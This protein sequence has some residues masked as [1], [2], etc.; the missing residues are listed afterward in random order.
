[1]KKLTSYLLQGVLLFAPMTVTIY[2]IYLV[3]NSLDAMANDLLKELLGIHIWGL[4][5]LTMLIIM[6]LLGYMCSTF[7]VRS[8]LN[9]LER[10]LLRTPLVNMIYGS[11]KDLFSAFVSDQKKFDQPVLVMINKEIGLQKM[12]FLT[13]KELAS[14][15]LKDKVGVYLPHS[16]NFSGNF[17]IIDKDQV[18]ILT[19]MSSSEAM[20]FIISGGITQTPTSN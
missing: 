5:L 7:L 19:N 8:L 3:M 15:G 20:K 18:T 2:I 6:T 1:M 12:G 13:Q 17:F 16:Y 11:M 4:G 14:F 10:A 9:V